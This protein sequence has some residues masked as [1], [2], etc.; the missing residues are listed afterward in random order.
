MQVDLT[1]RLGAQLPATPTGLRTLD[2]VLH[3]GFRAGSMVYVTGGAGSGKTGLGLYFAYMSA[4]A[5]AAAMFVSASMDET[6][7]MARLVARALYREWPGSN[8]T[9][10]SIWSGVAWQDDARRGPLGQA[11]QAV[12][13]KVGSHMYLYRAAPFEDTVSLAEAVSGLWARHE[14]VVLVVDD[15]EVLSAGCAGDT[16]AAAVVNSDYA[17]R[18]SQVAYE[19][20][21]IAEQGCAV[22]A[23]LQSEDEQWVRPAATVGLSLAR[24]PRAPEGD[25]VEERV[26]LTVTKNRLGPAESTT[27]ALVRGAAI[28][29]EVG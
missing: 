10:G 17:N 22:V 29:D 19:L 8:T 26:R 13:S 27:L 21:R 3:G 4:R 15:M 2:R 23:T 9:Y 24:D 5:G 18:M 28:V 25:L 7:I 20:A 14:R 11:V 12:V 6:E 16:G 1:T